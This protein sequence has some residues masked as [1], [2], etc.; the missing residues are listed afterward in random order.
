MNALAFRCARWSVHGFIYYT[1]VVGASLTLTNVYAR[2]LIAQRPEKTY[3]ILNYPLFAYSY[4]YRTIV[5]CSVLFWKTK[6]EKKNVFKRL[7]IRTR[8][9]WLSSANI[10]NKSKYGSLRFFRRVVSQYRSRDA[11]ENC[12]ARGIYFGVRANSPRTIVALVLFY[13]FVSRRVSMNFPCAIR[14]SIHTEGSRRTR[15]RQRHWQSISEIRFH[16]DLWDPRNFLPVLPAIPFPPPITCMREGT[17]YCSPARVSDWRARPR[18]YL[19]ACS[20]KRHD[21]R[22]DGKRANSIRAHFNI[23]YPG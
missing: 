6:R 12:E 14:F 4:N 18:S 22:C 10:A 8:C 9:E 15:D 3:G 1:V 13:Q 23:Y 5:T 7:N 19:P 21:S 17:R 20:I 11:R 2:R 16:P